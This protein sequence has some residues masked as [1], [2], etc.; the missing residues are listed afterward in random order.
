VQRQ[1]IS[2]FMIQVLLRS[3]IQIRVFKTEVYHPKKLKFVVLYF[4]G[5][6]PT[7]F[8]RLMWIDVV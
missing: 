5:F 4:F 1:I 6:D 2:N 7:Y 3:N 8:P